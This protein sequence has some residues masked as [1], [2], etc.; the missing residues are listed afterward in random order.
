[1]EQWIVETIESVISQEGDFEIEYIIVDDSSTDKTFL[2][3]EDYR[4]RLETGTYP[5]RCKKVSMTCISQGNTGMYEAINRGFS[6]ATGDIYA[7]I[8]ADDVYKP[9]A[10]ASMALAFSTFPEAQWIKGITAT[11]EEDSSETRAGSCKLYRQDWLK[12]GIYGQEAYFV[13]QD[14]VFWKKELW[15]KSGPIPKEMRSAGDY[16]LWIQMANHAPL[17]SL[18]VPISSFRK[19]EGQI[20]KNV[21][22]YKEEQYNIRPRKSPP[23]WMSRLFFT[24]E[25]HI[26]HRFPR[27]E[28]LL[29]RIYAL[30]FLRKS[31]SY[32][33]IRDGKAVLKRFSSYKV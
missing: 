33:E 5:I 31:D 18:N 22:R 10:F 13:E 8:N 3:A 20:S 26:I 9:R 16:W 24:P 25:S 23:A 30:F 12:L 19:R 15:K 14:S 17:W 4:K 11:I 28:P 7:W 27:L 21:N 32:I 29:L 6:R 2:I 1:M